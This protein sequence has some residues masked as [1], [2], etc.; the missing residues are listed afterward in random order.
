M[1]TY[2]RRRK[3]IAA[4]G[5]AVAW[6]LAARAQQATMPV[7]GWLFGVS[8]EAG[9]PTLAAFL[10]ALGDAGYVEGRNIQIEYRWANGNYERLP[11]MAAELVA[12]PAEFRVIDVAAELVREGESVAV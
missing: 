12:R 9:Q 8:S 5:S 6:P 7:I 11:A 2:I 4:L 3:F 1:A 10:K